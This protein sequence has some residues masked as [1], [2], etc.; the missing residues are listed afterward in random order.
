MWVVHLAIGSLRT[1]VIA[2][3]D[4]GGLICAQ[5]QISS[6][7]VSELSYDHTNNARPCLSVLV[8]CP[9]TESI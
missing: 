7:A 8:N 6:E 3:S 4:R 5:R 2:L 1:P 9:R